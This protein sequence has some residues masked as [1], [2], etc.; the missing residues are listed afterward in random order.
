MTVDAKPP[1]T[2]SASPNPCTI[3]VSATTCTTTLS[4]SATGTTGLWVKVS[5]NGSNPPGSFASSGRTGSSSPSWIQQSPTHSYVF[6]LYDYM[7]RVQG[8][9]LARVTVTGQR[10]A[11]PW[12]NDLSPP[13]GVV[14][15]A[16]TISG[17]NFGD[18]GIVT[19]NAT[20]GSPSSWSD[21]SISVEVPGGA[22]SGPV[23]VR[24]NGQDSNSVHFLVTQLREEDPEC[25][26]EE[27]CPK[28]E[29]EGEGEDGEDP[30]ADP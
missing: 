10:P 9:E 6:Y 14:G 19:F 1:G 25:E 28:D 30:P 18:T 13:D 5:H 17:V 27:D 8:A 15:T 4:W 12:I 22:T 26:D 7:D 16:V 29:E 11:R 2:I 24:A 3:A 23:V 20:D 21:T